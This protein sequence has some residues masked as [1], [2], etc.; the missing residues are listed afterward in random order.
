MNKQQIANELEKEISLINIDLR[1]LHGV[2][3][4]T[5]N[6]HHAREINDVIQNLARHKKFLEKVLANIV[7]EA[8]DNN[9]QFGL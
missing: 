4:H 9:P 1:R 8:R 3:V 5:V 7:E 6:S 2:Y